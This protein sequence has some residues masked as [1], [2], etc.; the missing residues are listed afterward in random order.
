MLEQHIITLEQQKWVSKL[1][2]YDYDIVLSS[3]SHECSC[4]CH[5][6]NAPQPLAAVH[7]RLDFGWNFWA[8][9]QFMGGPQD[10]Q[11]H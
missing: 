1:V 6:S 8:L 2:G 10:D 5:V 11:R 3:G 7:H 4:R 9:I